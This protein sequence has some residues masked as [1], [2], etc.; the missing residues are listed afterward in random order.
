MYS[1]TLMRFLQTDPI[2]FKAGDGNAYRANANNPSCRF[3]PTGCES[4]PSQHGIDWDTLEDDWSEHPEGTV[5]RKTH[6]CRNYTVRTDSG[7]VIHVYDCTNRLTGKENYECHGLTFGGSKIAIG[8][9]TN[10]RVHAEGPFTPI[11]NDVPIILKEAW[12]WID[13]KDATAGDIVVWFTDD[14]A[15]RKQLATGNMPLGSV[16]HSATFVKVVA[17]HG[18]L[19][20]ALSLVDSKNGLE[21]RRTQSMQDTIMNPR[22]GNYGSHYRCYRRKQA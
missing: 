7:Q 6:T 18:E 20:L 22:F 11:G 8:K 2:G 10:N 16:Q 9:G 21:A 17:V 14:R 5:G 13:C 12:Q 1:P 3:D 15:T 19:Q 4:K